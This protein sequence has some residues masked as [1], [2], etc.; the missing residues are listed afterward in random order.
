VTK[1]HQGPLDPQSAQA[2]YLQ[3][4]DDV[5][6]FLVGILRDPDLAAEATQATFT[7]LVE[8]GNTVN[9]ETR[10]G[11][12]FRVAFNQA[13]LLRRRQTVQRK[14]YQRLSWLAPQFADSPELHTER[15]ELAHRVRQAIAALPQEQ[16]DVVKRRIYEEQTFAIIAAELSVPL[17]TVLSR[18]RLGLKKL[19]S[20]LQDQVEESEP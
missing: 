15:R 6:R 3:F 9:P 10:R 5:Q 16:R 4:H 12:L 2:V 1:D 7:K 17:G 13:M 8:V 20:K 19:S 18:M 14:S 11:W